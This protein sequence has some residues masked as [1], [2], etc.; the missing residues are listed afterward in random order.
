MIR[1]DKTSKTPAYVQLYTTIKQQITEEEYTK[2]PLT[3]VRTLA[4]EL[5]I[6]KNTVDQ[7]YQQLLAEGYI[8]SIPGSGY[9]RNDIAANLNSGI[10]RPY[11]NDFLRGA[12]LPPPKY[13]FQVGSIDNRTFPWNNWEKCIR[14][15]MREEESKTELGYQDKQGLYVLRKSLISY[16]KNARGVNCTPEQVIICG[17]VQDAVSLLIPLLPPSQYTIG[18]EDPGY[19]GTK[20]VFIRNRYTIY[21]IPV[22][23]KGITLEQLYNGNMNLVY[24]TPSHQFP[25]GS[26]MPIAN[27]NRLLALVNERNGFVIED[28]YDSE[29]HYRSSIVIPSL[30]SL[31]T[32]DRVI[33]L[34]TFSK[35]VS[36]TIRISCMILPAQLMPAYHEKYANLKTPAS[37]LIQ[38]A[39]Y[40]FIEQGFYARH[41]RKLVI[42]NEKKYNTLLQLL[43]KQKYIKPIATN[44]GFYLLIRINT[45]ASHA[46]TLQ[47]FEKNDIR[48]YPTTQYWFDKEACD[49]N[50][51]LLG[52]A[53]M[54][55]E[56]LIEATLHLIRVAEESDII[57][58]YA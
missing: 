32:N 52:Y 4:K 28:D 6:A 55:M 15:A 50:L 35:S 26:I 25:T 9:Y 17:G 5:N 24:V 46:D 10:L 7:A 22:D 42:N 58:P 13:N 11:N 31:D 20:N 43:D 3:P 36:P 34:G 21:P 56:K 29:F 47:M 57:V 45:T 1:I 19:D 14:N 8:Y 49:P 48:L 53:S 27:R 40:K 12:H 37:E 44:S 51:F 33:Y 30:Q 16:L 54:S 23:E 39:L 2:A 18:F 38:Y 41:L